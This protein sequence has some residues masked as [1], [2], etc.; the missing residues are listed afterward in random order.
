MLFR[1]NRELNAVTRALIVFWD[2]P[3]APETEFRTGARQIDFRRDQHP[4]AQR[5]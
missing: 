2:L 1:Y 4:D 5:A 3:D